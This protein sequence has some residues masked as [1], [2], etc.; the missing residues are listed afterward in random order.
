MNQN[1]DPI[2]FLLYFDRTKNYIGQFIILH[3]YMF[4]IFDNLKE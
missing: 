4:I 3:L 2:I 1:R